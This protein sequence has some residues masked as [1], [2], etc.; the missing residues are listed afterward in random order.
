MWL[1]LERRGIP[2]GRVPTWVYP[3]SMFPGNQ[4]WGKGAPGDFWYVW[5]HWRNPLP[6]TLLI[7]CLLRAQIVRISPGCRGVGGWGLLWSQTQII[8]GWIWAGRPW[9]LRREAEETE[10]K[11]IPPEGKHGG[12]RVHFLARG[13]GARGE[14]RGRASLVTLCSPSWVRSPQVRGAQGL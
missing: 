4:L 2:G 5:G 11:R 13:G 7:G 1:C 6:L 3:G 14:V 12:A 8:S 9:G 10:K